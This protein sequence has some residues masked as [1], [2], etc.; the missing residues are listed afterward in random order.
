[1]NKLQMIGCLAVLAVALM[2]APATADCTISGHIT[3]A[4]NDGDLSLGAWCYSLEMIWDT[5]SQ[6]ALSHLDLLID[7]PGGTCECADIIEAINFADIAGWSDGDPD[8]CLVEYYADIE[9]NG[10]PSIPGVDGIIFKWEPMFMDDGCEPGATGMGTFVFYSDYEPV[11]VD[12]TI[13]LLIEKND[14]Q[15]CEGGITGVV[16]GIPCDPV[17][18]QSSSWSAVKG[19]YSR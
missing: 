6:T 11:A 12:D 1:M 2:A 3:A 15:S 16:P 8:G 19:L 18:T 7:L 5:G 14:G 9:C 10:D 17:S 13:P 4:E